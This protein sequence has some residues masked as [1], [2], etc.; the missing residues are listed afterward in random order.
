[1]NPTFGVGLLWRVE[2]GAQP[3][4]M[5]SC[6]M[7]KW[8]HFFL[9]P[10]HGLGGLAP[11]QIRVSG[12]TLPMTEPEKVIHHD[13]ADMCIL[14]LPHLDYEPG[15]AFWGIVD[16]YEPGETFHALGWPEDCLAEFAV[17]GL[18]LP[19]GEP[20]W[21]RMRLFT[22]TYQRFIPQYASPQGFTFL[23]GEL[24]IACPVGLMGGPL[25][26][27]ETHPLVAGMVAG[28]LRTASDWQADV[29]RGVQEHVIEYG[30]ALMLDHV[31]DWL[32]EHIPAR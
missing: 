16:N 30:V 12:A 2:E 26:R 29:Q 15:D 27:P 32:N 6:F 3:Q 14:R 4:F 8:G 13:T 21:A 22:G 24:S 23:A 11:A 7:L 5:S 20:P 10:S 25:F 28:N 9:A 19:T 1:M 31:G 17:T 18:P